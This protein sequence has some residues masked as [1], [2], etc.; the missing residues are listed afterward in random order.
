MHQAVL[1]LRWLICSQY[2]AVPFRTCHRGYLFSGEVSLRVRRIS[3]YV[4]PDPVLT[5]SEAGAHDDPSDRYHPATE[6]PRSPGIPMLDSALD[7]RRDVL[8]TL[9]EALGRYGDVVRFSAGPPG[10]RIVMYP[11][12]TIHTRSFAQDHRAEAPRC[13]IDLGSHG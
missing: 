3:V 9:E 10:V 11:E 1:D 8:A 12:H 5:S 7:L 2:S 6:R 4:G 13:P